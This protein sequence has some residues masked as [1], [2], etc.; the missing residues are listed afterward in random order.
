M[1][2]FKQMKNSN[3]IP[4]HRGR[5]LRGILGSVALLGS[6]RGALS[7]SP[8]PV[9]RRVPVLEAFIR[10][11]QYH[12]GPGVIG[13]MQAGD[14][15]QLVREPGNDFD[16]NAIAVH[17]NGHHLGYLPSVHAHLDQHRS[18]ALGAMRGDRRIDD[19]GEGGVGFRRGPLAS[20]DAVNERS[21]RLRQRAEPRERGG[22]AAGAALAS[23]SG[24]T[25]N[26]RSLR[27]RQS[28]EHRECGG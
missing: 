24:D 12:D 28:A 16:E 10:G 15:L 21:L 18:G 13:R 5:F 17:W 1:R 23:G 11:F 25:V 7:V 3:S 6:V 8:A 22:Q 20:S 27:L 4:M 9:L 26:E 2:I 19:R 14:A